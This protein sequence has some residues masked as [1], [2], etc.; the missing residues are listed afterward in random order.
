MKRLMVTVVAGMGCGIAPS[1][2]AQSSV[3]LYGIVDV[4]VSYASNVGGHAQA[5]E[6]S[7][8]FNGNRFG[9]KGQEDLGGG[10]SAV[11]QLE[12]GFSANNGTFGQGTTGST[13]STAA[14]AV[15]R[16]FGRQAWVGIKSAWA[17][18][19][20]GRQYDFMYDLAPI[21]AS[22]YATSYM[23]RPGT[24]NAL[25]GNDGST[26][27][28]DRIGGARVDNSVKVS[29]APLGGFSLGGIYGFGGQAGAFS[30]G[31]TQG[32]GAKYA[33][34]NLQVAAAW[35][36][37]KEAD[38]SSSYRVYGGGA[39]YQLGPVRLSG[40]YTN[41]EWT[42]TGDR[43]DTVEFGAQY[44][45][46]PAFSLAASYYYSKPNNEAKNVILKGTRNQVGVVA[47][48]AFSKATD[49]YLACDYQRAKHGYAAQ[50]YSLSPTDAT[51]NHQSVIALGVQHFF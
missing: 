2:F 41:A 24:A 40:L 6:Q 32:A 8:I 16:L 29:S 26:T 20:L 49:V 27:D 46:T 3:T 21:A 47:D 36:N 23:H 38:A 37:L 25:L 43:V 48:Y 42:A 15:T 7:G 11:F 1:V 5:Q 34:G 18:V 44:L 14:A 28:L 10:L 17:T 39:R 9:F 45:I 33:Q 50:I 31:G 30:N 35:T 13:G 22:N 4:G 19:T 51:T 12:D